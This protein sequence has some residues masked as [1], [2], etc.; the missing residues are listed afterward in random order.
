MC[1]YIN[2]FIFHDLPYHSTD[3]IQPDTFHHTS[4]C[5][6]GKGGEGWC[7]IYSVGLYNVPRLLAYRLRYFMAFR[8]SSATGQNSPSVGIRLVVDVGEENSR[9]LGWIAQ[10][11]TQYSF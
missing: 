10:Y 4:E 11:I 3:R 8:L 2:D 1:A 9:W 7:I 6:E 5:V